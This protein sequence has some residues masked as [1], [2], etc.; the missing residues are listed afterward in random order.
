MGRLKILFHVQRNNIGRA[1]NDLQRVR[2]IDGLDALLQRTLAREA[3][4]P[5]APILTQ[6]AATAARNSTGTA[7]GGTRLPR[8][9]DGEGWLLQTEGNAGLIPRQIVDRLRNRSY[10]SFSEMQADFWREVARD[11]VLSSGF[12]RRNRILMS[13]GEA[14]F[15]PSALQYGG[16]SGGRYTLHHIRPIE[17]GGGVYDM[18]NLLIVSPRLHAG[19]IHAPT[20]RLPRFRQMP[21]E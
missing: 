17:H 11:D 9:L 4:P 2:D 13:R 10:G 5:T 12:N 19:A 20:R 18:D 21:L 8:I 16:A 3:N 14:P 7:V 15:A 1:V 6:G